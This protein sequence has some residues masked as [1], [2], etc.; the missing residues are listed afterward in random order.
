VNIELED[1]SSGVDPERLAR[2]TL[3]LVEIPSYPGN[4]TGIAVRYAEL[5][6]DA[7]AEAQLETSVPGSAS[8][9][10]RV[11]PE[12]GRC[13]QLSG[14]L[15]TVPLDHEPPRISGDLLYGR[16]AC[17]M[18]AGLAAIVETTR[19]LAPLLDQLGGQLLV[20]AYGLHEGAGQAP[21]HA[22]LRGLLA[23]GYRGDAAI[24]CEGPRRMLPVMGKGSLIFRVEISRPADIPDHELSAGDAPHPIL[25]A[26]QWINLT[27]ERVRS[28]KHRHPV[29]GQETLF[30]GSIHGGDLYNTVPQTVTI[31]GT[32]RYPP[33]RVFDEVASELD[34]IGCEVTAEFGV[35]VRSN[36]ERSGQPFALSETEPILESVRH[37][38]TKVTG[39]PLRFGHQL[40]SSD[41]NHFV[42]DAGISTAAYGVDPG[43][44]H[45][46][47]EFVSL[48]E[49]AQVSRVLTLAAILFFR[50]PATAS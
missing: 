25:A 42:C 44:A 11:G 8:V 4:E 47:P 46:T 39:G 36:Y 50:P 40:F 12:T 6:T 32:R 3:E 37:A 18:K 1:V 17:D 19:L 30:L 29:L 49:L 45:G 38:H 20:T 28:S 48:L 41:L 23:A 15:D 5:L 33:P 26:Q 7:G 43:P 14:H 2:T 35:Q 22:P 13:L 16:G 10:G 27:R 9:V 21:M 34:D 24:V 31:E